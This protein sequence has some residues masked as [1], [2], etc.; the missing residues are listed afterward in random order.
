MDGRRID[1][2]FLRERKDLLLVYMAVIPLAL[3]IPNVPAEDGDRTVCS[4]PLR[5]IANDMAVID[6]IDAE[7][8]EEL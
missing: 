1:S 3:A 6:C 8:C 2:D 4:A 7:E 5:F